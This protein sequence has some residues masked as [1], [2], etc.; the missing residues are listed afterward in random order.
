MGQS[1]STESNTYF[2]GLDNNG[3]VTLGGYYSGPLSLPPVWTGTGGIDG[4]AYILEYNAGDLTRAPTATPTDAPSGAPSAVPS[5][6][7]SAT[8]STAPTKVRACVFGRARACAIS[9]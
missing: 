7:P 1:T 8:P 5:S 2:I 3:N 4:A 6:R 9:D